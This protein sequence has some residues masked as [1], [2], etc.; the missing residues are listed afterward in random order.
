VR[1]LPEALREHDIAIDVIGSVSAHD[2]Q[3]WCDERLAVYKRPSIINVT[4]RA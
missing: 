1:A 4:A 2:V 3:R